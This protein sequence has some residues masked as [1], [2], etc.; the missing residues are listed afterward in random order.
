MGAPMAAHACTA[1][2]AFVRLYGHVTPDRAGARPYH[3]DR[4]YALC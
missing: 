3:G 4:P 1:D 2:I